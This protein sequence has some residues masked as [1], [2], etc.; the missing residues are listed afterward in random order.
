MPNFNFTQSYNDSELSI[1]FTD[2]RTY[3]SFIKNIDKMKKLTIRTENNLSDNEI[4][5]ST[6]E[7]FSGYKI[8]KDY[9]SVMQNRYK[10]AKNNS[11]CTA[12]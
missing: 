3:N 5:S 9:D 2:K 12:V 6:P 11:S 1:D 4:K 8:V 10:N 7:I